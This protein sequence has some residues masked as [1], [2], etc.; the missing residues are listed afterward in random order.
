MLIFKSG[1]K[2]PQL[3]KQEFI[4][5]G[6]YM[7][8]VQLLSAQLVQLLTRKFPPSSAYARAEVL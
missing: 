3:F 8:L 7:Q 5:T 6:D 1:F 4:N 2:T